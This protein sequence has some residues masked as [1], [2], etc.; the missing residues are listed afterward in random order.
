M[1]S[2][3]IKRDQWHEMRECNSSVYSRYINIIFVNEEI[4]KSNLGYS[5]STRG[6]FKKNA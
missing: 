2:G 3:V 5:G 1:F 6:S 4:T